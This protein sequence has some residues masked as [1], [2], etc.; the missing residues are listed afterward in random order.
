MLVEP[1]GSLK[2][3]SGLEPVSSVCV[4]LYACWILFL[5]VFDFYL[6]V[7]LFI[8]LFVCLYID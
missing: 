6:N 3:H 2:P 7:Y 8:Y 4:C 1:I 5:W